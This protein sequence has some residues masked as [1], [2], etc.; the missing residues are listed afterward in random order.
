MG[1]VTTGQI[2]I[3]D[4]N[5][6]K[7]IT[8]FLAGSDTFQQAYSKDNG[9]ESFTPSRVTTNLVVSAKVY[10]GGT[11][12]IADQL[13][14]PTWSWTAG[15]SAITSGSGVTVVAS[16]GS[17]PTITF[18]DNTQVTTI[19]PSKTLYFQG[20]YVDTFTGLITTVVCSVTISLL[21]IGTANAIAQFAGLSVV[22][23]GTTAT[24]GSTEIVCNLVR[25]SGIDTDNLYYRW[26]QL[27]S[28]SWV[29][30]DQTYTGWITKFGFRNKAQCST[31]NLGPNIDRNGLLGTSGGSAVPTI[32]DNNVTP[33][34]YKGIVIGQD[35]IQSMAFFKCRV[36][37]TV[38]ANGGPWDGYFT[39]I[40]SSDPY[41]VQLISLSGEK[42]QNGIGY[43]TIYPL[44]FNG[45]SQVTDLTI[46]T[47]TW[48]YYALDTETASSNPTLYRAAFIDT[49]ITAYNSPRT[50]GT[51]PNTA[52][53][54][55]V[56]TYGGAA[57][58]WTSGDIIK[59]VKSNGKTRYFEVA[60]GTSNTVTIRRSS[61]VNTWLLS[62]SSPL[63]QQPAL[64]EFAN[65]KL[66]KC[67]ALGGQWSTNGA[68]NNPT[69]AAIILTGDDVDMKGQVICDV[70]QN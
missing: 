35:L 20:N 58:T 69:A 23:R 28:G 59:I 40:D 42:L 36:T 9:A 56:I 10:A 32:M 47:F 19:S 51:T 68:N 61:L 41:A 7:S 18:S 4:N 39:I 38:D 50:L 49:S 46:Y 43:T 21:Q 31:D 44:V 14:S 22:E 15:G 55:S 37:D 53:D 66:Y 57:I 3:V 64:N 63:M 33:D 60:S 65:G 54:S 62:A 52:G 5:D 26:Y 70:V 25:A 34:L 30:L 12:N 16:V 11:I 6:A 1:L 29:P 27:V 45:G 48:T 13:T 17:M 67:K 2:T 24:K 8:A